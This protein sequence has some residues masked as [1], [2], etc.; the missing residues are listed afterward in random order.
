M[1]SHPGRQK[2]NFVEQGA[3]KPKHVARMTE[4]QD[5]ENLKGRGKSWNG[6]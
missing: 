4:I 5:M 2:E 1:S 3:K 6:L